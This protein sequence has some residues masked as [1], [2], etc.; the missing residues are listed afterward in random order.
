MAAA[1]KQQLGITAELIK[2]SG[3]IFVVDVD[4]TTVARKTAATGFPTPEEIV[5]AVRAARV[6]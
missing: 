5:D 4:G 1:L 3:G 2:G 6:V